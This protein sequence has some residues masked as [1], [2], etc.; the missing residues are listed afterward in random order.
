[1]NLAEAAPA[2]TVEASA[3]SRGRDALAFLRRILP[4]TGYYVAARP[5]GNGF[6]HTVCASL[7]EL[8]ARVLA[9][10]AQGKTSYH[11]CAAYR[12]RSVDSAPDKDGRTHKQVRVHANVRALKAFFMDLD[13]DPGNPAKYDS[14]EAALDALVDFCAATS[15]PIPMVISSGRG[16][17]CYVPLQEKEVATDA[18]RQ[19]ATALKAL[20][21]KLGFKADP[22]CTSDPARVLRTVGTFNRKDPANPRPVELVA[23][24]PN[25]AYDEF[26]E[27]VMAALQQHGVTPPKPARPYD[28]TK[29]LNETFGIEQDFPP[30]SAEKVA[31]R[32]RQLAQMRDTRGCISEP[33]WFAAIQLMCHAVEGDEQVHSWSKGYAGYSRDE[34]D[35]KIQQ[36]RSQAIGPTLCSTFE[37]R[38][39]GGCAGC[40]FKDKIS[41]P[42][43]LGRVELENLPPPTRAV[44][45]PASV[46][47]S[48]APATASPLPSLEARGAPPVSDAVPGP[49]EPVVSTL[50]APGS[51]FGAPL[52]EDA[53]ALALVMHSPTEDHVA[54]FFERRFSNDLRYCKTWGSW[55]VWDGARWRLERTEM[56]FDFARQLAREANP[57]GKA[58]IAKAAFARGV[59]AFARAARP[60]ATESSDWDRNEFL[61]NTPGGTV[62]LKTGAIR[63]HD[64]RDQITNVTRVTPRAGPMPI[65]D[66][67]MSDITLGDASL[68]NYHQRA[69]G[70]TLSGALVDHWLLFWI[71]AGRNGKNTLGEQIAWILNDYAKAIPTESLMST[72]TQGHPTEVANLRGVRL[73]MSS[74]VAEGSYWNESRIKSLTGDATI[75]ARFMRGDFFEFPR[76]HKHLIYG[77]H[78]PMLRVVDDAIRA[79][80]HVVPFRA[81]FTDALGNRDPL[82]PEK[83]REEAPQILAWL[84]DGHRQWV[85]DGFALKPCPAV[86][87]ETKD[88]LDTQSTPAL[89]IA[90]RCEAIENDERPTKDVPKAGVL[91]R[92]YAKF[93]TDRGEQPP[94]MNRWGEWMKGHYEA[95]ESDGVRYRGLRLKPLELDAVE[96]ALSTRPLPK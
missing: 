92:D 61:L 42:A 54:R 94:S 88:Y 34:T 38:S 91:Y 20:A 75:S 86:Q 85:E 87:Q 78:R 48:I 39:P 11:A 79:R 10:D 68:V 62:D 28:A 72:K 29:R 59:E 84:I 18:W 74:E 90:E 24:A 21:A 41:T 6:K 57:T 73:A 3:D 81:T 23:D 40:P 27:R 5:A 4:E 43:Q 56:A 37:G 30:F 47:G 83:L 67:F 14:Q 49:A 12:E 19:T 45:P 89:W 69:L 36:I 63:P 13:V 1:M 51:G 82:L 76:T 15:L 2:A 44:S 7:E 80:M 9:D 60:F 50:P 70:A 95:V 17:H 65:F 25:I 31:D 46:A 64:R 53:A 8:A 16:L 71:G 22:A 32:C 77:N 55:L 93:K 33:H 35:R 66:K 96:W 26:H 58:N 52:T